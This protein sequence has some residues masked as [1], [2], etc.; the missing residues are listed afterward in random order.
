MAKPVSIL[1]FLRGR[2]GDS[3]TQHIV[4]FGLLRKL[5]LISI[6]IFEKN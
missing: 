4:F 5:A 1:F 3:Q 6:N 2:G